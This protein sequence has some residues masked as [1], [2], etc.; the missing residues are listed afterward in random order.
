MNH[1]KCALIVKKISKIKK[2]SIGLVASTSLNGLVKCG[3][4]AENQIKMHQAASSANMKSSLK[5]TTKSN[6]AKRLKISKTFA[7]T[8]VRN[9]DTRSMS[10]PETPTSRHRSTGKPTM[11]ELL[12]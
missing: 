3:G 1:R 2:I 12:R 9:L 7:A 11:K 6:L 10:V 5:T 8:A 4:A